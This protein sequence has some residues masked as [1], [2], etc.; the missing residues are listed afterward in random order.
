MKSNLRIIHRTMQS[1]EPRRRRESENPSQDR[2]AENEANES[3]RQKNRRAPIMKLQFHS[4]LVSAFQAGGTAK[5]K[6]SRID[7]LLVVFFYFSL[8]IFAWNFKK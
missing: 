1:N 6:P 5:L 8:E 7:L 3:E 2:H 4:F